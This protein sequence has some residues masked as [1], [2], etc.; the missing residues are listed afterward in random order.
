MRR[1]LILGAVA[2]LLLLIVAP[3]N[4]AQAQLER[5]PVLI[6]F[7]S[8]PGPSDQALVRSAGGNIKHTYRLVPAIAASLPEG[9]IAGLL[10]NPRVTRVEPDIE[11]HAIDAELD[12]TWG[13]KRIGAGTVHDAGNKGTGV[14]VAVIDS[15]IDY[16]HPDLDA[17][18][19]PLLRGKDFVNDD[20]DPLDDNGHGTHV[21]GSIA[22]EDNGTGVVGVAPEARYTP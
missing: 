8:Q 22:A 18:F 4:A 21:A 13:V 2:S 19:D 7:A 5:V 16:T 9:A 12:N 6:G 17:N 15:G 10:A 14:K 11:I 3:A 20:D 1:W